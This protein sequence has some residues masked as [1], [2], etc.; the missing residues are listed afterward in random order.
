MEVEEIKKETLSQQ[1]ESPV[2]RVQTVSGVSMGV[3]QQSP[4]NFFAMSGMPKYGKQWLNNFITDPELQN[5]F[6]TSEVVRNMVMLQCLFYASVCND[7]ML[8]KHAFLYQNGT[9]DEA[10]S[11]SSRGF[12]S[13]NSMLEEAG[14]AAEDV[15]PF[16]IGIIGCG[17]V[18]TMVL[19]KLIEVAH[20]FNN[21]QLIVSTRQ[22]HLLRPFKE[23]FGIQAEFNN[24]KV[25]AECDLIFLCV[26]PS[27][28]EAVL[29]EV[30][31]VL[32]Q[33][34]E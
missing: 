1:E 9:A 24:E 2:A 28:A 19:T 31:G 22:P 4:G 30:R 11:T 21:L 10:K 18:G 14:V 17:Q 25:F 6:I 8:Y 32:D 15:P 23:E 5:T 12:K 29:K 16:K 20:S 26:L 3:G 7:L 34:L 13:R 27:Q 33:R